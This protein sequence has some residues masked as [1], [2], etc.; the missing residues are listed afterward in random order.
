MRITFYHSFLCPRCSMAGK[1]LR[2]IA[3]EQPD[4][5]IAEI[6]ITAKPFSFWRQG[7][8]LIPALEMNGRFLSGVFLT[9]Q[10][11]QKFIDQ[12]K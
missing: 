8:R 11:I 1:K 3:E 7:I 2:S 5:E 4:L 10:R 9:K 6:D 12:S